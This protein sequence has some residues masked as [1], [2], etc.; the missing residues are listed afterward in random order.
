MRPKYGD[1]ATW[2]RGAKGTRAAGGNQ[3]SGQF[4]TH[5]SID[6]CEQVLAATPCQLPTSTPRWVFG[7][8]SP[9]SFGRVGGE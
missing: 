4:V 9:R 2:S 5:C 7:L 3:L 1:E 8:C 6:T